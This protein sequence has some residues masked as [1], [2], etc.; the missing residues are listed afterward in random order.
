MRVRGVRDALTRVFDRNEGTPQSRATDS[1]RSSVPVLLG[2]LRLAVLLP[3][4]W[5]ALPLDHRRAALLHEAAHLAGRDDWAKTLE[6]LVRVVFFFHPVVCWLL[7]RLEGTRE[8]L[9][10]AVVVRQGLDPRLLARVL[11]DFTKLVGA[12]QPTL[13]LGKALPFFNQITIKDR[14]HQL[15]EADMTRWTIPLPQHFKVAL[16]AMVLGSTALLGTFGLQAA[17]PP[18]LN[19]EPA[20]EQA[21]AKKAPAVSGDVVDSEGQPVAGATILLARI[22]GRS[23]ALSTQSDADGKFAFASLPSDPPNNFALVLLAAKEG[24]APTRDHPFGTPRVTLKLAKAIRISGTVRDKD[25]KPIAHARVQFGTVERHENFSSWGYADETMLSGTSLETFFITSSNALGEFELNAVPAGAELIFRA[26]AEG[27]AEKDTGA[28]GPKAQYFARPGGPKVDIVLAP[29][30]RIM[31]QIVNQVNGATLQ[32]LRIWLYEG[33]LIKRRAQANAQGEF[34]FKG[35]PGG[36]FHVLVEDAPE[37]E[38]WVARTAPTIEVRAGEANKV[39][40]ELIKGI[41]VQGSVLV[42]ETGLPMARIQVF[43]S[44][45]ARPRGIKQFST[46]TDAEGHYRFQLPPGEAEFQI[47]GNIPADY[48]PV[49]EDNS[50]Q[51]GSR[52]VIADG[53]AQVMGPTLMLTRARPAGALEGYVRDARGNPVAQ[54]QIVGLCRAGICTRIG[55]QKVTTDPRGHFRIDSGPDGAFPLGELT[56]LEVAVA[57]GKVFEVRVVVVKGEV[58]VRLPTILGADIKGPDSV[59]PG[60]LAGVVVDEKGKPLEGVHVHVWDWVDSPENQTRTSKDGVF[61]I[62]DCGD[63]D[64]KVQ[65]RFRKPGFSPIMFV[66]QPTGVLGLVVV[67]DR[68]TYFDGIVYGPEGKPVANV[69]VRADQGPKMADG[70]LITN[71]WTETKTDASGN[72][73]LYVEPDDYKFQVKAPGAGVAR[74]TK[75]PIAHGQSQKLDIHLRPGIT[76]RGG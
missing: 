4:G 22:Q 31:G 45:A 61:R 9:C 58:E 52:A 54:A 19:K 55:G 14:I 59:K 72:Y 33:G 15:M 57:G 35:L 40:V 41:Q 68:K 21:K 27:F 66:Q 11:V 13:A 20:P 76:Y 64:Q 74:L 5:D 51:P 3:P 28:K 46:W 37:G 53:K 12:G 23:K 47:V 36:K 7:R 60:E 70:V 32:G 18:E 62:K 44:C 29:E 8:Q 71:I 65:V 10:D 42:K 73:R 75:I 30:A 1:S 6:E 43:A 49:R 48:T 67:M 26:N 63:R 24:F 16:S 25:N 50:L 56:S 39:Q 69:L 34:S 2:G 38:H 17:A